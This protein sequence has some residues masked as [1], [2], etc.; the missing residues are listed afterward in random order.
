MGYAYLADICEK[1]SSSCPCEFPHKFKP[2]DGSLKNHITLSPSNVRVTATMRYVTC[3]KEKNTTQVC[4]L[5][6][7]CLLF[8]VFLLYCRLISFFMR[9]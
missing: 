9:K 7:K 1:S 5:Y 8:P 6:T 2:K 4:P 3:N